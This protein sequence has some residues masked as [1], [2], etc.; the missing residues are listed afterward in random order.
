MQWLRQSDLGHVQNHM[1]VSEKYLL[2]D[3]VLTGPDRQIIKYQHSSAPTPPAYQDLSE[4]GQV[5]L[6]PPQ[7]RHLNAFKNTLKECNGR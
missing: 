2:A 7:I 5:G 4:T 3:Q 1:Y 6:D